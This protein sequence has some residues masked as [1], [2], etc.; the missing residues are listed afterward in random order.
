[1]GNTARVLPQPMRSFDPDGLEVAF[2][3]NSEGLAIADQEQI[4][5]ANNALARVFGYSNPAELCGKTLANLRPENQCRCRLGSTPDFQTGREVCAFAGRRQDGSPVQVEASC[6][7]FRAQERNLA[8]ITIRD[9]SQRERRRFMRDS[10]RRFRTIFESAPIG[11]VQCGLDGRILETNPSAQQMLGCQASELRGESFSNFLHSD[12]RQKD[13]DL[14]RDLAAGKRD[15]YEHELRFAQRD[16]SAGGIHLKV[17]L[18]RGFDGNPHFTLAMIEDITERIRAEQRLREAQKMEAIGRLV[19]GVAHDFNNLL[20][21]ITLYCDLLVAGLDVDSNLRRHAQEIRMAGEQGAALIQQLLAV[22]RQQAVEPKIVCPNLV[23]ESTRHLLGRLVGD[24]IELKLQLEPSLGNIRIDPAQFQQVLFNLVLNARDAISGNGS[25]TVET[26][27]CEFPVPQSIAPIQGVRIT[28]ADTGCGMT[29]EVRARLF[30]PF[31]TTK[32]GGRGNGLGLATVH[33]LVQK[34]GGVIQVDSEVGRGSKFKVLLPRVVGES[35]LER[36]EAQF[37]PARA[38]ETI[39]L[40]EDNA[41]VR[42]P[43]KNIL[44]EAGYCELEAGNG[45]EAIASARQHDRQI[46]LLL[47]DIRMPGISGREVPSVC[48]RKIRKSAFSICRA[49]KARTWGTIPLSSSENHLP[50]RRCWK[51]YEKR[52]IPRLPRSPK[53]AKPKNERNHDHSGR[54]RAHHT[55]DRRCKFS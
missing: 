31:F 47:A 41:T 55:P 46:D 40:V 10:D 22:S 9:L 25:I 14:F 6:S 23:I 17:S 44:A 49:T 16:G 42:G 48:E 43:A 4:L 8:V 50:E 2:E 20:T 36:V 53:N 7:N 26:R 34:L 38:H 28:V 21:G 33:N 11:I 29:A 24:S 12:D 35:A 52:W 27:N 3:E 45:A 30:E 13:V 39:L 18:V 5:Y 54:Y 51:K 1:M 19:G 15:A 37:S 32:A